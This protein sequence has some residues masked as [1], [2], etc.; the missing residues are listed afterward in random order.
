MRSITDSDA[1]AV[2]SYGHDAKLA[3]TLAK[4]YPY[5]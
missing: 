3:A 4:G 2:L 1:A 5:R